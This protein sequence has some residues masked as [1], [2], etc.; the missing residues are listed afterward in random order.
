MVKTNVTSDLH[1]NLPEYV[2]DFDL[3]LICGDICP[4]RNHYYSYQKEWIENE[5]VE[6]VSKLPFRNPW[7]KVVITPGNHDFVFE[8]W[9]KEDYD[10]LTRLTSGRLIVLRNEEYD[11]E[12]IDEY[13]GEVNSLK[14]FGTPYCQIFGNWAFMRSPEVLEEKFSKIPDNVDILISHSSPSIEKY[15]VINDARYPKDAGCPVLAKAI[16]EKKPRYAFYGH[17]HSGDHTF[18]T[19]GDTKMANVSLV[20]EQYDDVNDVLK[21]YI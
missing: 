14:I 21:L 9:K 15:G 2:E 1:G 8:Y 11:F 13:T 17:I 16:K 18:K 3:M 12:Y 10:N 7:S 5:F 6:W 4:A 20:N 19:V